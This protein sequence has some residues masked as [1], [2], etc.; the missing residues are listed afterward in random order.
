MAEALIPILIGTRDQ[1]R[2]IK[3]ALI[4][5]QVRSFPD[6]ETEMLVVYDGLMDRA[7]ENASRAC[8]G[9]LLGSL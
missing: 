3:E 1:E 8:A 2:F 7:S 9:K 6:S 5:A 4:N